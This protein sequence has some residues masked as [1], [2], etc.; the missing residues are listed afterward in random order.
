MKNLGMVLLVIGIIM[1]VFTGFTLI[2][3]KEVVDLGA[4]EI[5]KEERT[6]IYWSPITGALLM[7][8]GVVILLVGR[9]RKV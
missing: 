4:V 6:P 5:N 3:K 8:T 2:T 7:A 9:N 1:T